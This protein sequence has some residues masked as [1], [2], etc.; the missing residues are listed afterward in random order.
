MDRSVELPAAE[1]DHKTMLQE[2]TQRT[3]HQTPVYR[4]ESESGPDHDKQFTVS[5][6]VGNVILATAV[7]R[8]KKQAERN[9]AGLA[10]DGIK[11]SSG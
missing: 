3:S 4:V 7:G 9:A 6:S 2:F 5:V 11:R 1:R 8:S 10:L